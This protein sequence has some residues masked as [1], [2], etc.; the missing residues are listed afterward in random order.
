MEATEAGNLPLGLQTI[1]AEGRDGS[2][3]QATKIIF[4]ILGSPFAP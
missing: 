3:L 1:G 4:E 2:T